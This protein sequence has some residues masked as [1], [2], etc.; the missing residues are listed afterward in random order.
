MSL[1][2]ARSQLKASVTDLYMKWEEACGLWDDPASRAFEKEFL[3][4][5]EPSAKAALIAMEDMRELLA[6]ARRECE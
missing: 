2:S 5:M 4:P 3:A 1:A 6:K